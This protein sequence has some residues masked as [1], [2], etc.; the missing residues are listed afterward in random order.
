M[1]RKRLFTLSLFLPLLALSGMAYAGST[2]TDRN[3]WPSEVQAQTQH[4][5]AQRDAE[6][7]RARAQ[8]SGAPVLYPSAKATGQ[9]QCRYQGGPKSSMACSR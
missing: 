4:G 6:L 2:V 7:G 3:Y 9:Q 8:A 5:A 1:S